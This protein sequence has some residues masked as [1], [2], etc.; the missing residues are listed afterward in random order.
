[1]R[2]GK[3]FAGVCQS[4]PIRSSLSLKFGLA[5][6]LGLASISTH[7]VAAT[8]DD[9]APLASQGA[10]AQATSP[11]PATAAAPKS[12]TAVPSNQL[13]EITVTA[14][15]KT[16]NLESTPISITALSSRELE[17][18]G[19][20]NI[21]EVA[22]SAPNLLFSTT[23]PVSGVSNGAVIYMRGVGQNDFSLTTDPGVG[24]YIDGIYSSRSIG[25]VQDVLDLDHIEVLRGPQGTLF[26]RNTIGGAISLITKEPGEDFG[27]EASAT[28]GNYAR[29]DERLSVD[30][31]ITDT[32]LTHFAF[33]GQYRDGYVHGLADDRLLGNVD[34]DASRFSALWKPTSDLKV[35]FTADVSRTREQ[36]AADRLVG[37][38]QTGVVPYY[39]AVDAPILNI[40][41]FGLNVPYDS[42]WITHND[43]TYATGPNG[44]KL[45]GFGT[46]LI[47]S[48][49]V[50]DFT[51]KSLSSFRETSGSFNRDADGSPLIIVE[52]ED[53]DYY[54]QQYSEELQ[55]NGSLFDDRLTVASGLYYFHEDGHDYLTVLL[56]PTFGV[57]TNNTQINN[58]SYAAYAQ[59]H[60][61][62]TSSLGVLAGVRLSEDDKNYTIPT[63]GNSIAAGS[64][65][66][67]AP[68]PA[69]TIVNLVPSGPNNKNFYNISSKFGVDYKLDERTLLYAT[70]SEGYKGG[71]FNIR[72]LVPS[73]VLSYQPEKLATYETGIKY[74][75]FDNRLRINADGFYSNYRNIQTTV[76]DSGAPVTKNGGTA[77]IEGFELETTVLPVR[78]LQINAGGGYMYS[79]YT[80]VAPL[81]AVAVG[82]Q[83]TLDTKLAKTPRFTTNLSAEY[84]VPLDSLG[85]VKIRADMSQSS[86]V[87][88][89]AVNSP[90]LHQ[91]S[92]ILA[93]AGVSYSPEKGNWEIVGQMTNLS[94]TRYI[95]SGDSNYGLGFHEANYNRPREWSFTLR[96]W[97]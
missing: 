2:T 18:R 30:V 47:V 71:G 61:A 9:A 65:F 17:N 39:N 16:A 32:L 23:A 53:K 36:N 74:E 59:L 19:L 8:Q 73:P 41:G 55:A 38:T 63:N 95:Q 1:M 68:V 34:R 43:T 7:A 24:T 45:D 84:T 12:T 14:E 89:D 5:A 85:A 77:V 31:P 91:G 4:P 75:G 42:R 29:H 13:E 80:S 94:N 48:K 72:Y 88:N 76:Y 44:T 50:G 96:T 64:A 21:S 70:Y 60:Y 86:S 33:S 87:E 51:L 27:G 93:N 69:G 3:N 78:N 49:E 58:D 26:G 52:T 82:P 35:D 57:L 90:Y 37:I 67:L 62:V 81:A 54:Q 28:L 66:P 25:G 46:S 11:K 10:T 83:I 20:T 79:Y 40:P 6:G 22:H 56:P 15:R 97:F 92:Y